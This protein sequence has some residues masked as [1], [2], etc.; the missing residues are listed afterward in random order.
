MPHINRIVFQFSDG[1][2]DV[3]NHSFDVEEKFV[4]DLFLR[5]MYETLEERFLDLDSKVSSGTLFVE[6]YEYLNEKTN[7]EELVKNTFGFLKNELLKYNFVIVVTKFY[8]Y[9]E[10][11]YV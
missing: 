3:Y 11:F 6:F 4:I 7:H 9:K 10:E 2:G 5:E 8:K 1:E